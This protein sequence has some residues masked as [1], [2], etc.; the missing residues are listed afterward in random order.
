MPKE[1][2]V[3]GSINEY[4]ARDFMTSFAGIEE[5]DELNVRINTNGGSP[6]YGYGIVAKIREHA[7]LKNIKVDGQAYSMGSFICIYSDNVTALDV[8]QFLIHRAA[9]S[10]W[11]EQSEYFTEAL[12]TNLTNINN[13]LMAATKAKIDVAKFEEISGV[14]LKDVFSMEG[15]VDVFLNAKQ[16]KEIGLI[17]KIVKITP[18]KRAEIEAIAA[19]Y[20][21]KTEEVEVNKQPENKPKTDK[22]MTIEEIKDKHPELYAQIV[23][24]GVAKE[25]D[26][27]GAWITYVDADAKAVADAIKAGTELSATAMA[28]LNRKAF[29]SMALDKVEEQAAAAVVTEEPKKELTADEKNFAALEAE[30]DTELK[31][32]K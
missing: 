15:R 31:N 19:K 4:S 24:V 11:F 25:R 21:P 26:R 32:L 3:Y 6:E 10:E 17:D 20:I 14:K 27:V 29:A 2:L 30:L 12:K 13:D 8:S 1:V 5:N 23:N 9:Y 18:S 28:E 16:A 22:K 7:G